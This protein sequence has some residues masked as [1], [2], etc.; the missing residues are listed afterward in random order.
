MRTMIVFAAGA[1]FLTACASPTQAD[2]VSLTA[3]ADGVDSVRAYVRGGSSF[4]S[5]YIGI[6]EL[7][8]V[9]EERSDFAFE[10]ID[11]MR[12]G[13]VLSLDRLG[14]IFVAIMDMGDYRLL[15]FGLGGGKARLRVPSSFSGA[16]SAS[17]DDGTLAA[18]DLSLSGLS[19]KLDRGRIE[20]EGIDANVLSVEA[21]EAPTK[22]RRTT[23]R[24]GTIRSTLGSVSADGLGGPWSIATSEGSVRLAMAQGLSPLDIATTIG[25]V[26][27]DLA[28]GE[29]YRLEADTRLLAPRA[30]IALAASE[31]RKF[32]YDVKR[33]SGERGSGGPLI[34]VNTHEGRVIITSSAL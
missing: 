25:G 12:S 5:F 15:R 20:L 4:L 27:I 31:L 9:G 24:R 29:P 21:K 6:V 19:L 34:R 23:T 3:A 2:T 22:I 11:G 32:P 16:I 1:I 30:D 8:I 18:R 13:T 28:A 26:R 7:E 14:S 33:Y 10:S 17:L